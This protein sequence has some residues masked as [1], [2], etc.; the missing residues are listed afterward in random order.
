MNE[1]YKRRNQIILAVFIAVIMVSSI[2][3]L[4]GSNNESD[5]IEYKGKEFVRAQ[6]G[7]LTHINNKPL[8]IKY[9]PEDL[10]NVSMPNVNFRQYSKVYISLNPNNRDDRAFY[11]LDYNIKEYFPTLRNFACYEDI[12]GCEDLPLKDCKDSSATNL[13][14]LMKESNITESS[15]EDNCLTLNGDIT[16]LIDKIVLQVLLP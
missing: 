9:S 5:K 1:K 16:K 3:G 14:I 10:A 4:F 15:Y 8:Y 6:S 13:I 12:I 7:W 11:D 2:F